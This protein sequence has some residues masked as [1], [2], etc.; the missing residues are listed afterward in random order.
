MPRDGALVFGDLVGNLDHVEMV[1]DKCTRR[2]RYSVA[3]LIEQY[4]PD[5]KMTDWRTRITADCQRSGSMSDP[6]GAHV[7][8]L[9]GLS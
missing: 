9:V 7:P 4:G 5:A 8:D 2:G 1:C 6:C 3:R